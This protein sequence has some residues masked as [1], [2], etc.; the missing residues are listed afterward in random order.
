MSRAIS[1]RATGC[2]LVLTYLWLPAVGGQD[3]TGKGPAGQPV[4]RV[5]YDVKHGVAKDLAELL[6]KLFR[7]DPAIQV[8]PAPAGNSLVLSAPQTA[9]DDILPL[10]QRLDRRPRSV[11]MEVLIAEVPLPQAGEG[12]KAP[13]DEREF[14]GNAE[15]AVAKL[16]E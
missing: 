2:L 1:I 14:A 13:L 15:A 12:G 6:G 5:V 9:L 7:N 3:P 4:K 10:L 8:L 16:Q 11:A